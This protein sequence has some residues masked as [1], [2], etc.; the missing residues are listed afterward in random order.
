MADSF[1]ENAKLNNQQ[2][3]AAVHTEGPLL[4]LAGAG[5]GKTRVITHRIAHLI[6]DKQVSPWSILAI[7]F[8][9]K[10]A[11]EMKERIDSV[12]GG[13]GTEVWVS[14]FHSACV[15]ILRREIEALGYGREFTIYDDDDQNKLISALLEEKELSP[16]EYPPKEV[17]FVIG[18]AKN[19]MQ[20]PAQLMELA[21]N[22]R[23][24]LFAELY[25]AY[26]KKLRANNALDFD[27]LILK[28]TELFQ[29][30]PE[31]LQKY[32]H[33][34][35]YIHVDEYQ[36]TNMAQYMLIRQLASGWNNI[37]VVGDDD[38]SIY[39]WRGADIRNILE[40]E[41]DFNDAVVIKLEQNYR[42]TNNILQAANT[43]I[44]RNQSRK[45]KELWSENG[46]G[47]KIRVENLSDGRGE[48]AFVSSE[49]LSGYK[50]GAKYSD[51]AVL[52]RTNSQSRVVEEMLLGSGIPYRVYGGQPFY[53]RK[54]VKD[55][56]AYLRIIT[57]PDDEIALR[58]ILNVPRRGIGDSAVNELFSEAVR[59]G[60]SMLG[61]IL[62]CETSGLSNRVRGKVREFSLLT[63]ELITQSMLMPP[64][65]FIDFMLE[66][67]GLQAM[68]EK[69]NSDEARERLE[70]LKE[71][72]DAANTYFTDN[73]EAGLSD[74]LINIALVSEPEEQDLF[75][76]ASG[77]V[78]LMTLHS[79]KGLEF[80]NVFIVGMEEG[81][82]PLSR[83]MDDK[84]QLEE[85]RRLCYVG[86]TR[87]M[88]RLYLTHANVRMQYG[89]TKMNPPSRFLEEIPQEYCETLLPKPQS[90]FEG[91]YS[92]H[93]RSE[94]TAEK[95]EDFSFGAAGGHGPIEDSGKKRSVNYGRPVQNTSN[96][97]WRMAMRVRHKR[98]GQGR[99]IAVKG[100][101]DDTLLTVAF[102]DNGV[103]NLVAIYANLEAIED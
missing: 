17:R 25:A 20:S 40:F 46:Q 21:T 73:P 94:Y 80:K 1:I 52:Y 36:D 60:D 41:K 4:I 98:F 97:Q 8:T 87:A 101:G 70:N 11:K 50:D 26:E 92:W 30:F 6:L 62:N 64:K 12:C 96:G 100:T 10:A 14:T 16:K 82:F 28:T 88:R 85:E 18:E 33:R 34:F 102:E 31:V 22:S 71:L 35:R 84:Q 55:A 29:K 61:V 91:G 83:A 89:M 99:I 44:A 24:E 66:K 69:E 51:F 56:I 67:T 58:R 86:M 79:A 68:Y 23:E 77:T 59:T 78:S 49:I 47:D 39:G 57:N 63:D 93:S 5:S 9:N 90:L 95:T 54:E 13:E 103:K 15:R 53:G 74:Y 32:A 2:Y 7:T 43:V 75:A 76:S 72:S 45:K 81:I 3:Q 27:D 38:Q 37:C 65:E 19:I 48:A 42:S